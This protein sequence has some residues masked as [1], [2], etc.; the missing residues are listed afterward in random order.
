[1]ENDGARPVRRAARGRMLTH[2]ERKEFLDRLSRGAT[3]YSILR[4]ME[5]APGVYHRTLEAGVGF[6]EQI[7]E[8]R[9]LLDQMIE[10]AVFHAAMKGNVSAQTLWIRHRP[11]PGW[12]DED[13]AEGALGKTGIDGTSHWGRMTDAELLERA[14][15]AGVDLPVELEGGTGP[16]RGGDRASRISA[17]ITAVGDE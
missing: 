8:V 4:E 9:L 16:A 13:E 17:A 14:V 3:P 15:A 12:S 6:R 1:M 2:G 11:P 10:T 7:D 5:I